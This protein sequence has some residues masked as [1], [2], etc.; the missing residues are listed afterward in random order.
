MDYGHDVLLA[1]RV[2]EV[3]LEMSRQA[4]VDGCRWL[5]LKLQVA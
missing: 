4:V 2:L 3:G 5:L 1:C